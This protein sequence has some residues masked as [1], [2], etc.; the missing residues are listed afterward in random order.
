MKLRICILPAKVLNDGTHK[1]RIAISHNGA[2]RYFITRFT[3]PSEKNLVDGRVINVDNSSYIN[4]QLTLKVSKI[5]EAFDKVNDVEYLTCS[6]L[7]TELEEK[8]ATT[9]PYVLS[10]IAMEYISKLEAKG[11]AKTS[12]H[13]YDLGMMEAENFFGKDFLV[14][15]LTSSRINEYMMSLKKRLSDTTVR[16][17]MKFLKNVVSYTIRHK[18]AIFD[19]NPMIDVTLPQSAVRDCALTLDELRLIR[20]LQLSEE[21]HGKIA[22]MAK[23]F[24]MVSFYLC[25]MNMADIIKVDLSKDVVS[26]KRQKTASRR[27]KYSDTVFTIQPEARMYISKITNS[28]GEVMGY[29]TRTLPAFNAVVRRG[30]LDISKITGIDEHRLTFYSARKTFAQ[31][32]NELMIKDSVI[33]Y[34]LGDSISNKKNVIGFYVNVNQRM[35]DRAIR[36]VFD[37]VASDK[38]ID[39]LADEEL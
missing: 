32:A 39:E 33:E 22:V 30:L 8:M 18:Y 16:M 10:D 34:C 12:K 31:L 35:A 38:S 29:K 26:F 5:Y 27:Q 14:R 25:G 37:A 13:L 21:K 3:V 4:K 7:V 24:F 23:N 36:K 20:D 28:K 17:R 9:K 2:T 1:I 15:N 11:L 6:Q 19:V